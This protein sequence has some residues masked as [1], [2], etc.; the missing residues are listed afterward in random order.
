MQQSPP[1]QNGG[2][3][4]PPLSLEDLKQ[5]LKAGRLERDEQAVPLTETA[6]VFLKGI[7]LDAFGPDGE[8]TPQAL[9]ILLAK[10]REIAS[11]HCDTT[12][13]VQQLQRK[14]EKT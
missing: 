3:T 14:A 7:D 9:K 8:L 13:I 10:T 11:D 4:D 5:A 2:D 12:R 1:P 6:M